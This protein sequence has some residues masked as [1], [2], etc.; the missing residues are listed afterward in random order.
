MKINR[1]V[2]V[3][4]VAALFIVGILA[5]MV[6][7]RKDPA[8]QVTVAV[9]P[10]EASVVENIQSESTQVV[11]DVLEETEPEPTVAEQVPEVVAPVPKTGLESTNPAAVNLANGDIQLIEMFAF[12]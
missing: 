4:V 9:A 2:V 5:V 8:M 1:K 3:F 10:T 6:V 7:D 11:V 12:W